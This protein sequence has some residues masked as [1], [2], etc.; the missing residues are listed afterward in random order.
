MTALRVLKSI[1]MLSR[2][3][4]WAISSQAPWK[5]GEGSTTRWSSLQRY[6]HGE[7]STSARHP[8][9]M[10]IWSR[11]CREVQKSGIKSPGANTTATY[12]ELRLCSLPI[13][14]TFTGG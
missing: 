5:Q 11:L 3:Q 13:T 4:Q 2:N 7:T 10:V 14:R 6:R 1:R 12:L 9:G 8:S